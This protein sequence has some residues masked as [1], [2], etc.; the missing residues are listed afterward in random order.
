MLERFSYDAFGNLRPLSAVD[1]PQTQTGGGLTRLAYTGQAHEFE[2]GLYDY[3]AR[4]YDARLGRFLQ[5]DSIVPYPLDSQSWNAYSYVRNNPLSRIDPSG[6]MDVGSLLGGLG[7]FFGSIA[8]GIGNFFGG[9]AS[10]IGG[11][12][13]GGLG[14]IGLGG[15]L[16]GVG[17]SLGG[18]IHGNLQGRDGLPTNM[19]C[20]SAGECRVTPIPGG[21]YILDSL[22]NRTPQGGTLGHMPQ[23]AFGGNENVQLANF[24]AAP[25]GPE[26]K[27]PGGA[28]ADAFEG[29]RR[30]LDGVNRNRAEAETL[31]EVSQIRAETI[32]T[33]GGDYPNSDQWVW[34]VFRFRTQPATGHNAFMEAFVTRPI[35]VTPGTARSLVP[36]PRLLLPGGRRFDF[37]DFRGPH[38]TYRVPR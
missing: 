7:N 18:G 5:P 21:V 30:T 16:G 2:H 11:F 38:Q 12:F 4:L 31:A 6:N 24:P 35:P 36:E 27:T 19:H 34:R 23:G 33:N 29:V 28:A 37:M 3:G 32:R 15:G 1:L 17:L 25:E 14:G 13:G 20:A 10:G 8:S 22:I 26:A 9:L